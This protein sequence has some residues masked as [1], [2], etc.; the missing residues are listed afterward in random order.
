MPLTQTTNTGMI[1][2]V[3]C[4]EF[5]TP[6]NVTDYPGTEAVDLRPNPKEH[7]TSACDLR[8]VSL[9]DAQLIEKVK[10]G[11]TEVY[12][13]LVRKYQDRVFNTCWR[14]CGH[15][16]DARDLTQEAFLKA[17]E[18]LRSFR[19]QSGFYTWVFRIAVN[20][21]L[22]HRRSAQRRRAAS[23]DQNP[24]LGAT[25]RQADGLA[26]WAGERSDEG[27]PAQAASDAELQRSVIRA[28]Q[29]LEDDYRAVVVLRD[30][31]GLDYQAIGEILDI[32]AG[33]VKSRLHRARMALRQAILPSSTHED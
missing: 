11:Q 6:D 22:T 1:L 26:K 14:I 19:R 17:F 3:T 28:L 29:G 25:G 15:L 2:V 9:E 23:L 16:E 13:T 30:I 10:G 5:S 24:D 33:T 32:P 4:R 21:A 20:L 27:D 8:P 7:E 12:G 18:G 31:E